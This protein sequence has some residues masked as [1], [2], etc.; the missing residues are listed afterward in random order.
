M[1]NFHIRCCHS[2]S[3]AWCGQN[4]KVLGYQTNKNLCVT[5]ISHFLSMKDDETYLQRGFSRNLTPWKVIA[6]TFQRQVEQNNQS[7]RTKEQH[8]IKHKLSSAMT[9]RLAK[10]WQMESADVF[11][12]RGTLGPG[13][14]AQTGEERKKKSRSSFRNGT[15]ATPAGVVL[16]SLELNLDNE[17][18]VFVNGEELPLSG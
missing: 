8:I 13:S 18:F 7:M 16:A 17:F 10:N 11:A 9:M 4:P 12:T 15:L 5:G 3:C 2:S 1:I 6:N 14:N